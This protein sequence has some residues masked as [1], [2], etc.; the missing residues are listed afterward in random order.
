MLVKKYFHIWNQR[1]IIH[2]NMSTITL[3]CIP[4]LAWSASANDILPVCCHQYKSCLKYSEIVSNEWEFNKYIFRIVN[5][6]IPSIFRNKLSI[7]S[8]MYQFSLRLLGYSSTSIIDN[9]I[10]VVIKLK[11]YIINSHKTSISRIASL[12]TAVE[13][14]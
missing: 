6:S 1:I 4:D 5:V 8:K 11:H 2:Q 3:D 13:F 9:T 14:K 7:L 10:V 12:L